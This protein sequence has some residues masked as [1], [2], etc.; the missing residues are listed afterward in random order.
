[1]KTEN[2]IAK[3]KGDSTLVRDT[4]SNA[5]LS[6]DMNSLESYRARRKTHDES[7]QEFQTLKDEVSEIKKILLEIVNKDNRDN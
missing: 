2:H 5:V 4:N 7:R 3:I 1:M 6:T